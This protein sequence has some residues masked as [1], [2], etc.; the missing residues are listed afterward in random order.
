MQTIARIYLDFLHNIFIWL[1][2]Y[3]FVNQ[4]IKIKNKNNRYGMIF[5]IASA[6]MYAIPE[7]FP[8][9][10]LCSFTQTS[11]IKNCLETLKNKGNLAY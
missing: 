11:H 10:S 1:F 3:T 9:D 4:N 7:D 2:L 8:Y 5:M 6:F